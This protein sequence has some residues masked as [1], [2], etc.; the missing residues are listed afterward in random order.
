MKKIFQNTKLARISALIASFLVAII[1]PASMIYAWGPDRE[2]FTIEKPASFITFNSITN[3]PKQGDERKFVRV[4]ESTAPDSAYG[5]TAALTPG[6]EYTVYIYYHNNAAINYNLTALNT[7]A[8]AE[9]PS[10]VK[11]GSTGTK[12]VGYIGSSNAKP[13]QVWDDISFTNK[14]NADIALRYIPGSATIHNFGKTNGMK[15]SDQIVGTG[16]PLGYNT[17]NGELP[18]CNEY[19]GYVIFNIRAE[20]PNFEVIKQVRISGTK[21][22]AKSVKAKP[23]DKIDYQVEY[24]N[25]GTLPQES[26]ILKDKLSAGLTFVSGSTRLKN[27]NYT[28]PKVMED[29]ITKNGLNIGTYAPGSNAFVLYSV[30]VDKKNDL[31]CK[32][33]NRVA[34]VT[35]NGTKTDEAMVDLGDACDPKKPVTP[36]EC[37]PG[38]PE[39]DPRCD[40]PAVPGG[41]TPGELPRTGPFEVVLAVVG[42]ALIVLG[43]A[44][45]YATKKKGK[46]GPKQFI[47]TEGSD[48]AVPGDDTLVESE[49]IVT[50]A[51]NEAMTDFALNSDET[52]AVDEG[53]QIEITADP[54]SV[55]VT[56]DQ[57]SRNS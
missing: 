17:L 26:V 11:K 30:T 42:I 31:S 24:K 16:A 1:L 44:Y 9:I 7:Y 10:I 40:D 28:T 55:E 33:P 18:G 54:D 6:K 37:K 20:Q 32:L 49:T 15:I 38:I 53:D 46:K 14:T 51:P 50:D 12:G 29:G 19:A 41:T 3:N 56:T 4:K 36:D 45:W 25:T 27:A 35:Q 47:A 34:A 13:T 52:P 5:D 23:G 22:W 8:K 48:L 21:T 2:T 39:G 57:D 43:V